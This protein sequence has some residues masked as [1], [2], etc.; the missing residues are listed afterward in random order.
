MES[1]YL[2]TYQ[3]QKERG[4]AGS[5]ALKQN[6]IPINRQ[7]QNILLPFKEYHCFPFSASFAMLHCL[8]SLLFHV[9][10]SHCTNC[11]DLDSVFHMLAGNT[12]CKGT[13][14]SSEALL[15]YSFMRFSIWS[16][17]K[18]FLPTHNKYPLT[19]IISHFAHNFMINMKPI[20]WLQQYLISETFSVG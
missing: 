8:I 5:S 13:V 2:I 16:I 18:L 9:S 4:T 19:Q 7:G 12:E 14:V 1:E 10:F 11:L 3:A 20:T 6:E 17:K 15:H